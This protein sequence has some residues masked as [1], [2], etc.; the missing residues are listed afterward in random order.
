MPLPDVREDVLHPLGPP[1]E[2]EHPQVV[3]HALSSEHLQR[4]E[5]RL[6]GSQDMRVRPGQGSVFF[7]FL[8]Q[9]PEDTEPT[10]TP[11]KQYVSTHGAF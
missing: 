2:V 10:P 4:A 3:A 1:Q 5:H 6:T 11:S 8:K 7:L 9:K